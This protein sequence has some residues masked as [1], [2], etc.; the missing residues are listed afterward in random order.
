MFGD[1]VILLLLIIIALL[2]L[3]RNVPLQNYALFIPFVVFFA[4]KVFFLDALYIDRSAYMGVNGYIDII[5]K[6][7]FFF[8]L[9]PLIKE[10]VASCK[11]V[12]PFALF[13]FFLSLIFSIFVILKLGNGVY[14]DRTI[15]GGVL[16]AP[17]YFIFLAIAISMMFFDEILRFQS[18]RFPKIVGIAVCFFYVLGANYTTQLLFFIGGIIFVSLF[19]FIKD[20]KKLVLFIIIYLVSFSLLLENS[21]FILDSI[22]ELFFSNNPV[23]YKRINEIS[24][25]LQFQDM[26]GTDFGARIALKEISLNSFFDNPFFGIGFSD[27][28][29]ISNLNLTIGCHAQWYDDLGR[30]GVVGCVLYGI[31]L[32]NG[33]V[34]ILPEKQMKWTTL[35]KAYLFEFLLYGF[36]NPFVDVFF[37][38]MLFFIFCIERR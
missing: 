19:H 7:I 31:F 3:N 25:L 8:L 32:K 34:M 15:N 6:L 9:L 26:T 23:I 16:L 11:Y 33:I 29:P 30:L 22:N 28:N 38:L 20:F 17:H 21:S 5:E 35:H 18:K 24:L 1:A 13:F 10:D 12:R 2:N 37:V 4:I 27:Y 36:F 14:R